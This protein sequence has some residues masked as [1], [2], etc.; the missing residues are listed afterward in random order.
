MA[1][2]KYINIDLN[3]KQTKAEEIANIPI[4]L[5]MALQGEPGMKI[6]RGYVRTLRSSYKR[7]VASFRKNNL[8]SHAQIALESSIPKGAKQV[9]LKEMT[10][11]QLLY[12]YF[13]YSKFFNDITSTKGGIVEVNKEQDA[14]IFGL[15]SRGRPKR[16]MSN[17]E[18]EE[19]WRVYEEFRNQYPEWSIA[20]Y[21]EEEQKILAEAMFSSDDFDRLTLI[22][23]VESVRKLLEEKIINDNIGDRPNVFSGNGPTFK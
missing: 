1:R 2:K 4:N 20:P 22:Q 3:K 7:R 19:Y 21:S 16:T 10:R 6:L 14:R 15:G 13:R 18:R 9:P 17:E 12:D 8:V 5:I 11:N 23:K